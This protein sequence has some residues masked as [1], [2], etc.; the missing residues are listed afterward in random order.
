MRARCGWGVGL[1]LLICVGS[2][3]EEFA[4]PE[5]AH[6]DRHDQARRDKLAK[7]RKLAQLTDH[8]AASRKLYAGMP[9]RNASKAWLRRN[10]LCVDCGELGVVEPAKAVDHIT[11]HKG[12][13]RLFW[14]RSNWQSLCFRCHNRK[15]AREVFH[16]K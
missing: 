2:G 16:G 4:L 11:S 6:C 7:R 15:T 3:C 12:D 13:V 1:R 5:L 9:W 8:A 14:D 10:P